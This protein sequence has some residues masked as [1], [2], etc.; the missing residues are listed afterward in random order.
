MDET[1]PVWRVVIGGAIYFG[2]LAVA[3]IAL[4]EEAFL[5]VALASPIIGAGLIRAVTRWVNR[6]DDPRYAKRPS[7]T[8]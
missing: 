2:I 8:P 5:I 7:D 4:G 3:L 6:R 1:P